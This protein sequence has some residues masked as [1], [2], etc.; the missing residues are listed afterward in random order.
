MSSEVR[1]IANRSIQCSPQIVLMERGG[2][3]NTSEYLSSWFAPAALESLLA[4]Q[5]ADS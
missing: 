5:S 1:D 3:Y 2:T 4:Y